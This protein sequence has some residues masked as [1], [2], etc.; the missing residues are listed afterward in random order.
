MLSWRGSNASSSAASVAPVDVAYNLRPLPG[1]IDATIKQPTDDIVQFTWIVSRNVGNNEYQCKL[2][3]HR[4]VG[5]PSKVAHHFHPDFG[6]QRVKLCLQSK[7]LPDVLIEQLRKA[8][9]KKKRSI[10]DMSIPST[11][12]AT[13]VANQARPEADAA[14]L[15]YL[16]C[17]GVPPFTVK[18]F[19]FRNML[20]KVSQAGAQYIP[21][22]PQ[23]FGLNR[24]RS[25]T[26]NGLGRVL[27]DETK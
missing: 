15:Q 11:N 22:L 8:S 20:K 12:I 17:E 5:Q 13:L 21:P 26:P 6:N 7:N 24:S 3:D 25:H 1:G 2:C 16:V 19:S 9:I 14:I 18:N 23:D 4:F 27:N 10:V